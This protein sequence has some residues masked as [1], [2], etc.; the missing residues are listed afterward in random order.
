MKFIITGS[1][2]NISRPLVALL[3]KAGHDVTVISRSAGKT[4]EIEEAGAKAAIGSLEDVSFL[5]N[6]FTGAD[7]VYTMVP[8]NYGAANMPDFIEATGKGYATGIKAAGVKKIVNLSSIGADVPAGTGPIAGLH[9]VENILNQLEGVDVKH[10]RAGFFYVNFFNDIPLVKHNNVIGANYPA[11]TEMI[12]VHPADIADAIAEE[13][14]GSFSGK[15]VRYAISEEKLISDI[16]P[17]IAAATGKPGLPWV[18]F[19]DDQ[20]LE[21]M[22]GAGIPAPTAATYVEMGQALRDGVLNK[23]YRANNFKPTGKRKFADFVKNEFT[24]A[25]N[26]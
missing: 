10:V 8:P 22:K 19:T 15:S 4:V 1:L 20:S 21:G 11:T 13:L 2:G 26:S 18:E 12:M 6:T 25:W 9:R 7:A 16:V 24:A 5:T 14:L 17:L 23:Y 3:V